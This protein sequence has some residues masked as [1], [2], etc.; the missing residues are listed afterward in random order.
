MGFWDFSWLRPRQGS[1]EVPGEPAAPPPSPLPPEPVSARL[2][3]ASDRFHACLAEVFGQEGG[4][5]D[6]PQDPGGATMMG[7]TRATLSDWRGY[8]VSE[9][10][11][12]ALTRAEAEAIYRARYWGP[13]RCDE[14]PRGVDL[15]VFDFGVNA[16][17]ARS[18]RLLQTALGVAADGII[19]PVTLAAARHADVPALLERMARA[20]EAYYRSLETFPTFGKGWLRRTEEVRLAALRMAGSAAA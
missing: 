18:A 19:G 14:L 9:A 7:I 4:F 12:R 20:R 10:E 5:A 1:S 15:M 16:G 11:V 13:L 3:P 17:P 2:S 8:Q 6:H